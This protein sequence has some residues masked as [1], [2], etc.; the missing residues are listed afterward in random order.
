M[1][2]ALEIQQVL[3]PEALPSLEGFTITSAYRPALEVG[4]DF[5]QIIRERVDPQS[6]RSAM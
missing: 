5:F 6:W 3:I 1:Q 2:S 4:G